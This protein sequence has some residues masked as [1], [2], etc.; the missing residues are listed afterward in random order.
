MQSPKQAGKVLTRAGAVKNDLTNSKLSQN[1]PGNKKPKV[2]KLDGSKTPQPATT[3]TTVTSN[4]KK[5]TDGYVC[6][7]CRNSETIRNARL[8]L[9]TD[10]LCEKM[11]K[12][13]NIKSSL[14]DSVS[15]IETLDLHLQHLLLD[16]K[17][18][19]DYQNRVEVIDRNC[20][21]IL[22]DIASLSN[23]NTNSSESTPTNPTFLES[24][25]S[26][27]CNKINDS[28]NTKLETNTEV[29][30]DQIDKISSELSKLSSNGV[31]PQS[32]IDS[33]IPEQLKCHLA[34]INELT[35][36]NTKTLNDIK[37]IISESET[38]CVR[39]PTQGETPPT[40]FINNN[41]NSEGEGSNSE[42]TTPMT[43]SGGSLRSTPTCPPYAKYVENVVTEE[44][45]GELL[46]FLNDDKD[47]FSTV[48]GCRD[49]LYFGE[50]GYRYGGVYHKACRTPEVIQDLLDCVRPNMA[51]PRDWINSCLINRYDNGEKHIPPHRDDEAYI[52]PES[53][54]IT[55]S[56][57]CKRPMKFVNNDSTVTEELP[58]ADSS[59]L[60]FT[61]YAQDFWTHTIERDDEITEVRYSFTFRHLYPG[62]ANSTAL[63]GDSNTRHLKF[64]PELGK[65]GHRM[66]GKQM[67]ALHIEDIPEP[68]KIGP[69]RKI[70]IHTGI[71]NVK[72]QNRKS[73]RTLIRELQSKCASIHNIYPKCKI[74]ISMLLPTKSNAINYRIREFNNLLLDMAHS[75]R[76]IYLIEHPDFSGE[77][78]LL[79][80]R[81]GTFR[82][83]VPNSI[84]TLHL[85]KMGIR[86]FAKEIKDRI[87]AHPSGTRGKA[88]NPRPPRDSRA[89]ASPGTQHRD[90]YQPPSHDD[91]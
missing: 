14:S 35:T 49:V 28:V 45:R 77:G 11:D 84:D 61:R 15:Q 44:L 72:L 6:L 13:D 58:L 9:E 53:E 1:S 5:D 37:F 4:D 69:Y 62:F 78:G 19:E 74:Y 63:I 60:I 12:I 91:V 46:N 27:I 18:F 7:I 54:I 51:N 50:Y 43:L 82:D 16:P 2:K 31:Q 47:N 66:P 86:V 55:V 65:F 41:I 39:T 8:K 87:L 73:N 85:G 70:V 17:R 48:G 89:A 80:D 90:G 25:I 33:S 67:S 3:S 52:D 76:N 30:S 57:G 20:N 56:I 83:G 38:P 42:N 29:I 26:N 75:Q 64:G 23:Y 81:F 71:N 32:C 36:N 10:L 40:N 68:E 79:K 59:V 22:C 88:N 21:Q 34:H 24:D